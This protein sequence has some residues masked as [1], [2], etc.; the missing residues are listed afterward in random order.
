[1]LTAYTRPSLNFLTAGE[2]ATDLPIAAPPRFSA[3]ARNGI[4][5]G[6]FR[7]T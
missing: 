4:D 6:P 3:T 5:V 2:Q 1:L 7:R